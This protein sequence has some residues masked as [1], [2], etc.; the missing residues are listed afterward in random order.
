M[1]Q[2]VSTSPHFAILLNV[3]PEH[4][5]YHQNINNYGK[6]KANIFKFQNENDFLAIGENQGALDLISKFGHKATLVDINNFSAFEENKFITSKQIMHNIILG[7][8]VAVLAGAKKDLFEKALETFKTL[9]HRQQ[10]I[11]V[12]K[13]ITFIDDSISTIPEATM[14]ALDAYPKTSILILGGMDRGIPYEDFTE[15]IS[16][17]LNLKVFCLDESGKKIFNQLMK[18]NPQNKN[19]FLFDNLEEIVKKSYEI[20]S[21]SGGTVLLSPAAASYTQFKNFEER[22]DAFLKYAIK[23]NV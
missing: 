22:G 23:Y 9:P 3:F 2:R 8:E 12:F 1:L 6:S 10:V 20:L 16:K 21:S 4:L 7:A 15:E 18:I 11:G 5:D 13:G 19:Y 14:I 17:R